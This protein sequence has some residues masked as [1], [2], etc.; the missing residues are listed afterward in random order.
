MLT[1][2]GFVYLQSLYG[3]YFSLIYVTMSIVSF[4]YLHFN[5]RHGLFPSQIQWEFN[6]EGLN[7]HPLKSDLHSLENNTQENPLE[8]LRKL[9]PYVLRLSPCWPLCCS[10][11]YKIG[12]KRITLTPSNPTPESQLYNTIKCHQSGLHLRRYAQRKGKILFNLNN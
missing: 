2:S 10:R 9:S 7:I 8:N 1:S 11:E 12:P 3:V 4:R 6:P 5:T